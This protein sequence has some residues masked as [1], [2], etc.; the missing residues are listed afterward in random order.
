[1]TILSG[2][3]GKECEISLYVP[4]RRHCVP[5][6][7]RFQNICETEKLCKELRS[8]KTRLSRLMHICYNIKKIAGLEKNTIEK[9]FLSEDVVY[10]TY[11]D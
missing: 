11:F 7:D 5:S 8:I 1:M 10:H 2:I 3:V 6:L 9:T 4:T